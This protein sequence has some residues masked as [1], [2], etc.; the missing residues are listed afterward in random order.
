M[1]LFTANS[2]LY[3]CALSQQAGSIGVIFLLWLLEI[4]MLLLVS[5]LSNFQTVVFGLPLRQNK[6][7]KDITFAL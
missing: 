2:R 1:L 5:V 6:Q 3:S 7:F 4:C